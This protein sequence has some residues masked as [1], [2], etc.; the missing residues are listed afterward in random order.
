MD[1]EEIKETIRQDL[2][3]NLPQLEKAGIEFRDAEKLQ[4]QSF[5][6]H[7]CVFREETENSCFCW[8]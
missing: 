3:E 4:N 8:L 1:F 2:L 6:P 5:V 7:I